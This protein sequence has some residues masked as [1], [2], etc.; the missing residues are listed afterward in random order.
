MGESYPIPSSLMSVLRSMTWSTMDEEARRALCARG[1][2]GHLRRR[3]EDRHRSDHRR[4][5]GQRRRGGLPGAARLRPRFVGT[6]STARHRRRDRRRGGVGRRRPGN[7]R[8]NRPPAGV[9]RA[10]DATRS[11]TGASR[12]S[13]ASRSARRSRRSAPRVCSCRAARPAIRASPTSWRAGNGRRRAP[14]RTRRAT[15]A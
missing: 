5:A 6:T 7:R 12:A 11:P 3:S 4:R 1:L 13:R 8:R 2:R 15:D 9:Q 10:A 14:A